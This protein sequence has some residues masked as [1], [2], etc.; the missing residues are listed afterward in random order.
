MGH[1]IAAF[2][3]SSLASLLVFQQVFAQ[4]IERLQTV[5]LGRGLDLTVCLSELALERF[6][7]PLVSELTGLRLLVSPAPGGMGRNIQNPR[8]GPAQ[9]YRQGLALQAELC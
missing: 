7:P 4:Q 5:Q 1:L 2:V 6:P 9:L 8:A 3:G